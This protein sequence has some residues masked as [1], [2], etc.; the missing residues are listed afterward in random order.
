MRV[1]R[2]ERKPTSFYFPSSRSLLITGRNW[3]PPH[4]RDAFV[5]RTNWISSKID[6]V[7]FVSGG[8][9]RRVPR[10]RSRR[11]FSASVLIARDKNFLK[12]SV[13]RSNPSL[14]QLRRKTVSPAGSRVKIC[15]SF[16]PYCVTINSH[17]TLISCCKSQFET[18]TVLIQIKPLLL[19]LI[20]RYPNET[21]CVEKQLK[22]ITSNYR[23]LRTENANGHWK[24]VWGNRVENGK[25]SKDEWG[26]LRI[27][28]WTLN[29]FIDG[30]KKNVRVTEMFRVKVIDLFYAI[31]GNYWLFAIK[32]RSWIRQ[33]RIHWKNNDLSTNGSRPWFVGNGYYYFTTM[34]IK[35]SD[36]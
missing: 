5:K 2:S 21:L 30:D 4:R 27:K 12:K 22:S 8:E 9:R 23:R 20:I 26:R 28:N 3:T 24:T 13:W 14:L 16:S 11:I 19:Y 7:S 33:N 17:F 10:K 32:N 31:L 29:F 36:Q 1:L 18:I 6:A 15:V 35:S 25:R 34:T